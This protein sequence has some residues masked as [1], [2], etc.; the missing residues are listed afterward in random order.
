MAKK[1]VEKKESSTAVTVVK[2]V[3]VAVA[4][5]VT[6]ILAAKLSIWALAATGSAMGMHHIRATLG[7]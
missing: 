5:P 3:A 4:V 1:E 6:L 2:T 7:K